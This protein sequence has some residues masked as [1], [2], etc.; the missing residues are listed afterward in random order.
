MSMKKCYG[1]AIPILCGLTAFAIDTA[2]GSGQLGVN[3][4]LAEQGGT[5][6]DMVKENYR[7]SSTTGSD[8]T[9]AQVDSNGWPKVDAQFL[10]DFRPAAEWAGQIDD[11]EVYRLDLSGTYKCAFTGKASVAGTSGGT[12][13]NAAYDSIGNVSNFDFVVTGT[14]GANYGFLQLKF[15][16]TRRAA[17]SATG[18]GITGFRMYRPGYPLNTSKTFTDAFLSALRGAN[19]SAIRFMDFLASNDREPAYPAVLEWAQRKTRQDAS[20]APLPVLGRNEGG[21][22]EYVA[23]IANESKRD[24][25]INVPVSATT[26]Y[27]Q[28]LAALLKD[29]LDP[30]LNIYVESGNEVWNSGFIQQAYNLAQAKAKGIDEQNNHARRTIELAQIFQGVFGSAAMN[31]RVRVVL[32]SHAPMLKWWV[33]PMLQYIQKTF[34]APADYLY[35]IACQGYFDLPATAGQGVPAI[36]AAAKT[37]ITGQIDETGG[38]NEAGRMQWIAKAKAWNLPGGFLIYEGGPSEAIGDTTNVARRIMAERDSGMGELLKYNYGAAFLDLGGTLAMQFTLSSGYTRYGC[39]GL[40]DDINN[41]N[42][43]FKYRAM[44]SLVGT[45][46][47]VKGRKKP[48]PIRTEWRWP[49]L[50]PDGRDV[51]G[52][53]RAEPLPHA[54]IYYFP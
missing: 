3:I 19:F 13:Q 1:H 11:P 31:H 18:S 24:A 4:N 12:V 25:W 16:N 36:L 28:H 43:N 45:S 41:P 8:L 46:N 37:S 39:W 15:T 42:R 9:A 30:S 48:A 32:C 49:F 50:G 20:Q 22:W 10:M 21:A 35:A 44:Q 14:S 7:W 33:E 54:L 2:Y 52:K 27:V 40:T 5:F 47:G 38:V 17:Q 51:L 34:G 26:D 53:Q 6:V 29:S 23:Q